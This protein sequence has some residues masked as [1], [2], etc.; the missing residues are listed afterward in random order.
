MLHSNGAKTG[1][2]VSVPW[3]KG[4][5]AVGLLNSSSKYLTAET[6]GFKTNANGVSLRKKQTWRLEPSGGDGDSISLRSHLGRYLSVD[7]FGNVT[8]D[9]EEKDVGSFFEIHVKN[10][11]GRWGLRNVSRGY[12]LGSDADKLTCTAKVPSNGQLW[13]L[14]LCARPQVALRSVG[15]KRYARLSEG[16]DEISVD[17]NVPWGAH[18]LFTLEFR[19]GHYALHTSNNKYLTR[20]GKLQEVCEREN[21]FSLEYHR[22]QLALRD[23]ASLYLAPIGSKAL[24]KTRSHTI[25]KDELFL[26]EDSLPQAAFVAALNSRF[27]SVKQGVDV[28]A[29][30]DE[31]SDDEMFQLEFDVGTS[32]WY[33]RT[34]KDKYWTLETQGGIQA[35]ADKKS[36]NALFELCWGSDGSV[37]FRGN[38]GKYVGAKRSGHLYAN[39]EAGE[40]QA[41]FYFY[42]VN[43]PK[44]VL[45]CEQGYVGY[46]STSCPRLECNKTSYETIGVE[47]D[48]KGLVHFKGSSGKYWVVSGEEVTADGEV[49]HK[50]SIELREPTRIAIKTKDGR[51]LN[52]LKNGKFALDGVESE[53]ATKWEF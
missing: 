52:A 4:I 45:K 29:N 25:T 10:E 19:D 41:K 21:L 47:R 39:C 3:E 42:L 2:D 13:S 40:E 48:Q 36:S 9:A 20:D 51:Y 14:H 23:C 32:R 49:P 12:F 18:T 24:L 15:R 43:R 8:C 31:I 50:F 26:L 22:G 30:Q 35:S 16:G 44:L 6:F 11:C 27:V 1:N 46:K 53:K 34:M 38:N 17:S 5:W 33:I 37:G 28:T 7:S